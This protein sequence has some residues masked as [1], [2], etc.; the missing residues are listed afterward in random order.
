[1][2]PTPI[3]PSGSHFWSSLPLPDPGHLVW[4]VVGILLYIVGVMTLMWVATLPDET[5]AGDGAPPADGAAPMAGSSMT[6][7]AP[8]P[9]TPVEG[10]GVPGVTP[11]PIDRHHAEMAAALLGQPVAGD[12][13]I[14][15][16]VLAAIDCLANR[17]VVAGDDPAAA[18]RW[19]DAARHILADELTPADLVEVLIECLAPDARERARALTGALDPGGAR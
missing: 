15:R 18:Q 11:D 19:E 10:A 4:W 8:A 3:P 5:A 1:M 6:A 14:G 17:D 9:G 16:Y 7:A 13:D 2:T 12:D